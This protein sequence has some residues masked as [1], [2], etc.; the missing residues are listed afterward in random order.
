[1]QE[2]HRFIYSFTIPY[3]WGGDFNREPGDFYI[4]TYMSSDKN[5]VLTPHGVTST[6]HNGGLIDYFCVS[7]DLT[8]VLEPLRVI[9]TAPLSPHMPVT[10]GL[11][12]QPTKVRQ[13]VL[14]KPPHGVL[15]L[16]LSDRRPRLTNQE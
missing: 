15:D 9:T 13:R 12:A 7:S 8:H 1:M 10:L 2:I 14:G 6:C 5:T 4:D 11:R 16:G 3:I